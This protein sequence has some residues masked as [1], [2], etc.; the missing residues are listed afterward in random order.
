MQQS[1]V[2]VHATVIAYLLLHV[3]IHVLDSVAVAAERLESA[4]TASELLTPV[5]RR[6]SR[7]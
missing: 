2:S 7:I 1:T 5:H 4:Y 3:V 6:P